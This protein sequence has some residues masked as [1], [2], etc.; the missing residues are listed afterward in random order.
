MSKN[1]INFIRT[2]SRELKG[3]RV[4]CPTKAS[5]KSKTGTIYPSLLLILLSV[6]AAYF[7]P[8]PLLMHIAAQTLYIVGSYIRIGS[9]ILYSFSY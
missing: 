5:C 6:L 9:L 8:I 2:L 4:V 3:P 1:F 7:K